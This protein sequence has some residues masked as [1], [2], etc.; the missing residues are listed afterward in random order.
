MQT[1]LSGVDMVQ[2]MKQI[3]ERNHGKFKGDGEGEGEGESEGAGEGE[4]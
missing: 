2:A 3:Q 1:T 4:G